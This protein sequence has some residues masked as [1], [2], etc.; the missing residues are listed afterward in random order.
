MIADTM[1]IVDDDENTRQMCADI[2]RDM[3]RRILLARD[4]EHAL[5]TFAEHKADIVLTDLFM[6][7]IGGIDLLKQLKKKNPLL[8]VILMSGKGDI[9]TAVEA[10]RFGAEDFLEKPFANIEILRFAV[11][12]ALHRHRLSLENIELRDKL[13]EQKA[14]MHLIG[15][16]PLMQ[17]I[18]KLCRKVAPLDTT[19]L[20]IGETGT[21]KEVVANLI[22]ANS[23]RAGRAFVS[24]NCAGLQDTLLE[25]TLFGYEQGAFTGA[26]K[27]T[28]GFFEVADQGTLFLDEIGETS[29]AVQ[30]KL[31]R[32][33]QDKKFE[34][35]G[36]TTTIETDIRFIAATNCD[37]KHLVK[38][39]KFRKDLYYRL[40]VIHLD[41]PPL[42]MRPSD[43][44]LLAEYFLAR[45]RDRFQKP[46]KGFTSECMEYLRTLEWPGNVRELENRIECA[47]GLSENQ[48]LRIEDFGLA[49]DGET[50][51]IEDCEHRFTTENYQ[52]AK[53]AFENR[54]W[55]HLLQKYRG[56]VTR[57]AQAADVHRQNLHVKFKQ[58]GIQPNLHR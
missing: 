3:S 48:L 33:L 23:R 53:A 41:L 17:A 11:K 32:V 29:P 37:L 28:K 30:A 38:E 21:G 35:L 16:S 51:N 24:I 12:K 46:I 56:N 14:P 54:F 25:S 55:L 7:K 20:I 27:R 50:T 42:R 1:L 4:G 5:I 44:P 8:P 10:V 26:A 45:Y 22:H 6:P 19:V 57:V 43:I 49:S 40:N 13:R 31:L 52:L 15:V 47:V 34:R 18:Q 39:G 9:Q 2:L 58:L 36:S